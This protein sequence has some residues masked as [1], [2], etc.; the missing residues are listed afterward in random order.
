MTFGCKLITGIALFC[1]L[2]GLAIFL[3]PGSTPVDP[4]PQVQKLEAEK[5]QAKE[6]A[7]A[8]E[9]KAGELDKS[10]ILARK[11]LEAARKRVHIKPTPEAPEILPEAS[12]ELPLW[13]QEELTNRAALIGSLEENLS[14]EQKKSKELETAVASYKSALSTSEKQVECLKIAHQAQLSAI[15]SSRWKGRLEGFAVGLGTG[16]IGAKL[17]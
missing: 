7:K 1:V 17:K 5:T 9:A 10:L 14:L 8:A 3:A 4:M 13:A 15:K 12:P 6:Q 16:F 11:D 2:F